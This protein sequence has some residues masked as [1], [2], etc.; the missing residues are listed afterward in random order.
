MNDANDWCS[1]VSFDY[2][3]TLKK[4]IKI[5]AHMRSVVKSDQH[6]DEMAWSKTTFLL[7]YE[8]FQNLFY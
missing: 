3:D 2:T 4:I 6:S 1:Q 5:L 7:F 8:H